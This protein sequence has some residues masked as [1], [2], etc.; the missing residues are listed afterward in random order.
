MYYKIVQGKSIVG[1]IS[2]IDFRKYQEKHKRI[3]FA[4][5]EDGQFIENKEKYYRDDWLRALPA[6]TVKTDKADIVRISYDEYEAL[7]EAF[8]T[9]EEI[10]VEE[11]QEETPEPEQAA[12][13]DETLEFVKKAKI[14][15]MSRT[16]EET[17]RRGFDVVLS[18]G[19][20]HHFSL[21]LEDQI[22]IQT[23]ALKAQAGETML[24]WHPDGELCTFYSAEDVLKI[25]A[26]LE[27]LQTVQT[28]YFNSLK[29]YIN[30]LTRI[31]D[32]K[33]VTY[34]MPIPEQFQSEVL[35]YLITKMED[36]DENS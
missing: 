5:E 28:T 32:V 33:A 25:Y 12:E 6:G 21:E 31:E 26:E 4:S 9:E 11:L 8:E 29:Y 27:K 30:S 10:E 36:N 35:R 23:L 15:K 7:K 24:Y 34:G 18:D 13:P 14:E 17:I 1:I 20:Q 19:K 3:L 2:S 16:C 22:K